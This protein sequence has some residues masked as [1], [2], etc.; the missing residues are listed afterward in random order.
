V[1]IASRAANEVERVS[2][3]IRESNAMTAAHRSRQP[4]IWKAYFSNPTERKVADIDANKSNLR[5]T[6]AALH[7]SLMNW[8]ALTW[9]SSLFDV[10]NSIVRSSPK[11]LNDVLDFFALVLKLN[12][13][14][15]GMRVSTP[16]EGHC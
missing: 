13:K 11:A 9:Q 7:V 4:E 2:S 5:H 15:A 10:Y 8:V 14:R 3:R 1:A 16:N 12:E 6:L